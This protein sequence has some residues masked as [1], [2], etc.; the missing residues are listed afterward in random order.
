MDNELRKIM[1]LE[2]QI[3]ALK[4]VLEKE[5][6]KADI[7]LYLMETGQGRLGLDGGDISLPG[8]PDEDH[9]KS[10]SAPRAGPNTP[11]SH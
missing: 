10:Q 4:A 8:S 1:D 11:D 7:L 3:L 5:R 2:E 9:P 6:M